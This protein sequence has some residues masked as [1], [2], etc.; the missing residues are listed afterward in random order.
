MDGAAAFFNGPYDEAMALVME[1]RGY[2]ARVVSADA[3]RLDPGRRLQA[4]FE[5]MR[6][7]SRLTQIMAWLLAQKAVFAG[8]ISLADLA[9]AQY[10][11]SGGEVC[12]AIG[13]AA[14]A[15]LPRQLRSLLERSHRLY[16]RVARLD[17]MVR[18]SVA[19]ED[20]APAAGAPAPAPKIQSAGGMAAG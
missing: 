20:G 4:S 9:S 2:A 8:E 16:Q 14:D 18:R 10:A 6:V 1:A 17:E 11:L 19:A 5:S 3:R 7:T 13:G 12:L 15:G